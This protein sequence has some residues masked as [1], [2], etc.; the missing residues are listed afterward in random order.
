MWRNSNCFY[1]TIQPTIQRKLISSLTSQSKQRN[2][3][4][5]SQGTVIA[6]LHAWRDRHR[7][8]SSNENSPIHSPNSSSRSLHNNNSSAHSLQNAKQIKLPFAPALTRLNSHPPEQISKQNYSTLQF[9]Q[10][11][12]PIAQP[13]HNATI[14]EPSIRPLTPPSTSSFTQPLTYFFSLL[15][16]PKASSSLHPQ[17]QTAPLSVKTALCN[18]PAEICTIF[19]PD[20]AL[21]KV[22]F[23]LLRKHRKYKTSESMLFDA[24]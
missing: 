5:V 7:E 16:L 13:I 17:V 20:N 1:T 15:P 3:M 23:L 19:S 2:I 14:V 4:N 12:V 21:I 10:H 9:L 8:N 11:S 6:N 22:G 18:A 24:S